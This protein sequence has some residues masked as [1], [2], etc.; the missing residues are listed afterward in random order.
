MNPLI[1]LIAIIGGLAGG[2]STLYLVFSFPGVILWKLYRRIV[3]GIP[4]TK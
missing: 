2:L 3:K 4:M 1:L